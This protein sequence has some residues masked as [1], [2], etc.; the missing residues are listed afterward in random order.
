MNYLKNL[1][2]LKFYVESSDI[3]LKKLYLFFF[4]VIVAKNP[5]GKPSYLPSK[6]KR[7][8]PL[9]K[10]HNTSLINEKID[11][12]G[13]MFPFRGTSELQ[14]SER[15]ETKESD[16]DDEEW[17]APSTS[18]PVKLNNALGALMGAYM[19]E[20]ECDEEVPE[21]VSVVKNVTEEPV[22]KINNSEC[23][24]CITNEDNEPPLEIKIVKE[25][26]SPVPVVEP[27][28]QNEL[29]ETQNKTNRVTRR[30]VLRRRMG[31]KVVKT[32][33]NRTKVPGSGSRNSDNFPY[34]F[35]KRE[36]T[37]LEKLLENEIIRERNIILQCVRYVI[38]N[39][40]F[41]D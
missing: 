12:N 1:F 39:N 7:K 26:V 33:I 32:N 35:K 38:S 22:S 20:S 30:K 6:P 34:K 11:W 8:K 9:Q 13:T 19:S 2:I 41:D 23:S 10:P 25:P 4:L 28:K 21:E 40:F 17:T 37:L 31:N 24:K 27:V 15:E 36:V 29:K 3:K 16:Y 14:Q 5:T 18:N